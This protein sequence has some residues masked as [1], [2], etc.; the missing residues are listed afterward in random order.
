MNSKIRACAATGR[1][2][3]ALSSGDP[4]LAQKQGGILK[5][6]NP[7]SPASMSILEEA[8]VF[9]EG[10]MMGVFNN[11][12]MYNQDVPQNS[13][14]LLCQIWLQAGRGTRTGLN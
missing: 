3:M 12:V 9:A 4:A 10:P 7:D 8:T 1:L 6:Y 2:L 5:T 14:S 13:C 11:L